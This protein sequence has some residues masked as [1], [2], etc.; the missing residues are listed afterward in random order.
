MGRRGALRAA[1]VK[2]RVMGKKSFAQKSVDLANEREAGWWCTPFG[3]T[4]T[5]GLCVVVT[6]LA[7]LLERVP[8]TTAWATFR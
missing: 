8:S 3:M 6:G 7:L 4:L 5:V 2:T 1:G